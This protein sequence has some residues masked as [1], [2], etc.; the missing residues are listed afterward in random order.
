MSTDGQTRYVGKDLKTDHKN[1]KKLLD[2]I[3]IYYRCKHEN[4]TVENVKEKEISDREKKEQWNEYFSESLNV[5]KVRQEQ[6]M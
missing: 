1:G 5:K 4:Q 2:I 6:I 3:A